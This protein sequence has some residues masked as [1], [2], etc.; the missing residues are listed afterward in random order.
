M[1]T[2]DGAWI[3]IICVGIPLGW[4]IGYFGTML[5]LSVWDWWAHKDY[6]RSSYRPSKYHQ[7]LPY[8]GPLKRTGMYI[9]LQP[10]SP[11]EEI[12]DD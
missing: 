12:K 3:F 11:R 9:T 7:V 2:S 5:V 8:G 1:T 4:G 10:V 6:Y